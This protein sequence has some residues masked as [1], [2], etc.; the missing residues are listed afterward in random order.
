M[1][2][3]GVATFPGVTTSTTQ[4]QARLTAAFTAYAPRVWAYARRH[5]E[6]HEC[7]DVVAETFA[8]AWRRLDRMPAEPLPWLLVVARNVLANRR[9]TAARAD[10]LWFAAV[11]E[12]WRDVGSPED[13]VAERDALLAALARCTRVE[14]EA[15]LLVAWEGLT[16]AQGAAVA[17]CS[18]RAFTVRLHRARR[19]LAEGTPNICDAPPM[20]LAP[21]APVAGHPPRGGA[22]A[23]EG[24]YP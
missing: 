8:I 7:D 10:R 4:A 13:A 24:M 23:P 12:L 1:I 20:R 14:R 15:L 9:R 2:L 19:R 18:T 5:T 6:A 22:L 21:P 3:A 16:P 11:H 17:G